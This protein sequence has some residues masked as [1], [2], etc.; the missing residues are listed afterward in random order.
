[1]KQLP[2]GTMEMAEDK[3]GKHGAKSSRAARACLSTRSAVGADG[4]FPRSSNLTL[5]F[6][7]MYLS[8]S[9]VT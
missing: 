5:W 7:S 6:P 9:S 2:R 3:R 1:V 4:V 8:E